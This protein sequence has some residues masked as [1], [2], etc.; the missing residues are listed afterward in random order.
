MNQDLSTDL[1]QSN[2]SAAMF[3]SPFFSD[4]EKLEKGKTDIE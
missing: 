4:I 3:H 2:I 1:N